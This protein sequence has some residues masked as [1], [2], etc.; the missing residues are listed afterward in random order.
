[1]NNVNRDDSRHF[2][3]KK[4]YMKAKI[5]ELKTNSK[6][7]YIRDMYRGTNDF[8]KGYQP[9]TNIV[10]DE[11]GNL[12]ADSHSN[13]TRWRNHFSQLL[14]VHGVN[15]VRQTEIHTAEPTVPDPNAFEFTMATVKLKR[16]KSPGTDQIPAKLFKAE[17]RTILS[18]IHKLINSIWSKEELSKEWKES[19][20]VPIYTHGN[21]PDCSNYRGKSLMPTM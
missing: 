19:I 21:K 4:E 1:M 20:N 10:M 2:R 18:E 14:N 7:K 6:I 3:N 15:N 12:V 17:G 11:K 9:R 8:K 13:L 16:H 5:E